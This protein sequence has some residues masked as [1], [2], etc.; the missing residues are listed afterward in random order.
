M[1]LVGAMIVAGIETVCAAQ[2]APARGD[3][4]AGAARAR[5]AV[6]VSVVIGKSANSARR[7]LI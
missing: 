5:G 4:G 7:T 3:S 2:V 1:V 6:S